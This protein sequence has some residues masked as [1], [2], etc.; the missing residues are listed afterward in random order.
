[1]ALAE[2]IADDVI[3]ASE[4]WYNQLA[5]SE[6]NDRLA[7]AVL[8]AVLVFLGSIIVIAV[9]DATPYKLTKYFLQYGSAVYF[10]IVGIASVFVGVLYYILARRRRSSFSTLRE[11]IS[12]SKT[13][14][15]SKHEVILALVNQMIDVLPRVRQDKYNSALLYGVIAFFLMAF[16]FPFNLFLAVPVWL[17]FRYEATSEYRREIM[18]FDNWKLKLQS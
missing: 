16:L 4:K 1:M 11:L 9:S 3:H 12:Q 5:S 14:D 10:E 13:K 17:Y 2:S 15:R 18:R 6:R 7:T 8:F